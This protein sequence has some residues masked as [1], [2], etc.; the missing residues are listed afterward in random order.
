MKYDYEIQEITS[1]ELIFLN[2]NSANPL[3]TQDP[4]RDGVNWYAYCNN[5]P[6]NFVDM[7]GLES[8]NVNTLTQEV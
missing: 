4:I 3:S 1:Y 2:T 7:N 5:S 6:L 8:W